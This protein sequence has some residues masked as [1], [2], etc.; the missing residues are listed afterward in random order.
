MISV[1]L[2]GVETEAAGVCPGTRKGRLNEAPVGGVPVEGTGGRRPRALSDA[3]RG[4]SATGVA[5]GWG[6]VDG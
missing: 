5:A 6:V 3:M 2:C 1:V 4:F